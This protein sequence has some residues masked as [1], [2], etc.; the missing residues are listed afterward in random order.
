MAAVVDE[1]TGVYLKTSKV[2]TFTL[3]DSVSHTHFLPPLWYAHVVLTSI[4]NREIAA[5][6][7]RLGIKLFML[8]SCSA[9][10]GQGPWLSLAFVSLHLPD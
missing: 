8:C 4:P 2:R 7:G 10:S 6:L 5:G 3:L 9:V 1:G